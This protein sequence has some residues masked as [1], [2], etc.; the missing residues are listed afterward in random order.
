MDYYDPSNIFE[1]KADRDVSFNGVP[2]N[3]SLVSNVLVENIITNNKI[4]YA[5]V[6]LEFNMYSDNP[7]ASISF[8]I[9]QLDNIVEYLSKSHDK[10]HDGDCVSQAY[11]CARCVL[12]TTYACALEY[13][14]EWN[15]Y[16][17]MTFSSMDAIQVYM[18]SEAKGYYDTHD[19][20]T[21]DSRFTYAVRHWT[22]E[23][24]QKYEELVRM[25]DLKLA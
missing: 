12:E 17:Q 15:I 3:K 24:Q 22:A 8:Q 19:D 2:Y 4:I 23:L 20:Y 25:I 5:I 6:I 16:K 21:V 10:Q 1:H 14:D 7:D 13:V 18:A 9:Q 11:T